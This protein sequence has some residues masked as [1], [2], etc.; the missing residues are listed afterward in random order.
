MSVIKTWQFWL[1]LIGT[2]VIPL[3]SVALA[4]GLDNASKSEVL[5]EQLAI[6]KDAIQSNNLTSQLTDLRGLLTEVYTR[7]VEAHLPLPDAYREAVEQAQSARLN[8]VKG[9]FTQ[10][11]KQIASA[12]EKVYLIPLPEG[13]P[14]IHSEPIDIDDRF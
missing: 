3:A 5:E 2:V 12:Y 14:L 11:S 7:L 1:S 13:P 9:D 4:Y 10:A 8:L 6:Q